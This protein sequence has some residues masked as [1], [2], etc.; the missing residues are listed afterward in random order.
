MPRQRAGRLA[1][2]QLANLT[3][4][5]AP[6]R[7]HY[8]SHRYRIR[9]DGVDPRHLP[10]SSLSSS[11]ATVAQV[12]TE[13]LVAAGHQAFFRFGLSAGRRLG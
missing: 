13:K 8:P 9:L 5:P 10:E 1:D 6:I 3:S 4:K 2:L 7:P 12:M 11:L